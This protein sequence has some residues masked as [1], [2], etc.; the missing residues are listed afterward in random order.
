MAA[1]PRMAKFCPKAAYLLLLSVQIAGV[2]I[3]IWKELPDLRQLALSPGRQLPY[4]P[5][6]DF[7]TIGA[8]VAMQAAYWYRL[9][10]IP[11]PFQRSG[12]L[13]SH[14]LFFLGRLSFI[15]GG[16]LFAVVFFRHLPAIEQDVD[17]LL[18]ARRALT[19]VGSLCS[20]FCVT[21]ELER[22]GRALGNSQRN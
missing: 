5:Y 8:V 6:D 21:L 20:L 1:I 12:P 13:L 4:I 18:M 14:L 2:F 15:F 19:L 3:I 22:L 11:I 10:Y 9:R 17:N 16:W 7:A